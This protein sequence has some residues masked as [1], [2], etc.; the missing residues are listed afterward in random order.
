MGVL[1]WL[2]DNRLL[3]GLL[4]AI[5]VVLVALQRIVGRIRRA[6][7]RRKPVQLNPKL[8]QY[9]GRSEEEIAADR[10]AAGRI[11]ATSSTNR[12]AG[13]QIQRQIE[14]VFVEGYRTPE[15]ATAAIKTAAGKLDANG[16]VNLSLQRSAAGR[17]TA[18]GD[19]VKIK[20]LGRSAPRRDEPPPEFPKRK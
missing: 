10:E 8:Q 20:P 13:Y 2:I 15:E 9:A 12:I 5:L 11:I 1:Q 6:I 18:Q 7:R 19:A 4:V 17:C 16:I 3:L 14:A